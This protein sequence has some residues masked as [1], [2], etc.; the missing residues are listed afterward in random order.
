[1]RILYVAMTR[2]RERLI[3]VASEKTGSCKNIISSGFL[4]SDGA[5]CDWLLRRCCK[6]LEW[7]L[8]GLSD[9]KLLH[10]IFETGLEEGAKDDK[11]FTAEIYGRIELDELSK[12]LRQLRDNKIKSSAITKKTKIAPA[13][14]ELFE[15]IKESLAWRYR[16]EQI[17]KLPAKDSVTQMTHRNDEFLRIDYSKA[18]SQKPQSLLQNE[19]TKT[20][21][22]GQIGTA[23]HL[24]LAKL[25]LNGEVTLD[26]IQKTI[27]KLICDGAISQNVAKSV[28]AKA[29]M[30]FFQSDLGR[31]I[32]NAKNVLREWPFS[33][34]VPVNEYAGGSCEGCDEN[35]V[36]QGIIDLMAETPK[37]LIVVDFKNDNIGA[38]E[39]GRRAEFYRK[40]LEFYGRAAKMILKKDIAGMWLYFLT[41]ATAVEI[42]DNQV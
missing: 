19:S 26:K 9:Q 16:F 27:N 11:L 1:M 18:L 2:A 3:L 30:K 28:N 35:I 6:P 38:G 31:E 23:V 37:G 12:Y 4:F 10:E 13:D 33:F 22:A 8:Y 14:R 39:A 29:I 15:K 25:N 20:V 24:V 5:I 17:C 34:A 36:V 42:K 7:I 21:D 40:Q 32:L 41:P